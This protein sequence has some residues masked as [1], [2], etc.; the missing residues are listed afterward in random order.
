[1]IGIINFEKHASELFKDQRLFNKNENTIYKIPPLICRA[2]SKGSSGPTRVTKEPKAGRTSFKEAQKVIVLLIFRAYSVTDK[3]RYHEKY[4]SKPLFKST[5]ITLTY[6]WRLCRGH[7]IFSGFLELLRVMF[8]LLT[9]QILKRLLSVL[10]NV[11]ES[12]WAGVEYCLVLVAVGVLGSICETHTYF[13]LNNA[14]IK[15]KTALI[16]AIFRKS[17][18]MLQPNGKNNCQS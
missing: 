6:I 1:M 16:S 4:H 3:W 8:L 12:K 17:L 15:M 18:K 7:I 13:Q 11:Q 14:G 9:P 2:K 5:K 10:Q